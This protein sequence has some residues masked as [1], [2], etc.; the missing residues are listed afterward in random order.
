[1]CRYVIT[2]KTSD[3]A[4]AGTDANVHIEL[5]GERERGG[6]DDTLTSSSSSS[7]PASF[8]S[9]TSNRATAATITTAVTS[10]RI[11]LNNSRENFA[12]RQED[13]FIVDAPDVGA[14]SHIVIGHDDTNL[15]AGWHLA[16]VRVENTSI[17]RT[18]SSQYAVFKSGKWF[19]RSEAPR[20]LEQTIYAEGCSRPIGGGNGDD[21]SEGAV[22]TK[23]WGLQ[24][25]YTVMIY[26]S[27]CFRSA[28][29]YL[30]LKGEKGSLPWTAVESSKRDAHAQGG[31]NV[32][33]IS[34]SDVG[35]ISEMGVMHSFG[36]PW[37]CVGVEVI[38]HHT[39]ISTPFS[40]H[41]WMG[42]GGG[43][44]SGGDDK[45]KLEGVDKDRVDGR[46]CLPER[47]LRAFGGDVTSKDADAGLGAGREEGGHL[48]R[49][50]DLASGRCR[51]QVAVFTSNRWGA[52]T[53][54]NVTLGLEGPA[55]QLIKTLKHDSA[56]VGS[57]FAV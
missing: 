52:G 23:G 26:T 16:E 24:V 36:T 7:F 42:G 5:C 9:R 10:P 3:V 21:Q 30:E 11:S 13:Y 51:Y 20:L 14:M 39:G 38:N 22:M 43:D 4:Y 31:V 33:S 55:G 53:S 28:S 15:G 48:L 6:P 57:G 37:K 34:G 45:S 18:G 54:A 44:G 46:F 25:T 19:D 1:M 32:V 56:G 50:D 2:V 27:G 49:G 29:V 12:R 47:R 17:R 8:S 35:T 41:G 40:C